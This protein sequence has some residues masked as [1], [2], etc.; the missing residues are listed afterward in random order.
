MPRSRIRVRPERLACLFVAIAAWGAIAPSPARCEE[1]A[2]RPL[3]NGKDLSGWTPKIRGEALGGEELDA[4]YWCRNLRDPVRFDRALAA[5]VAFCRAEQ[6]GMIDCQQHTQH[7]ASLGARLLPR[8]QF[9]GHLAAT[10]DAPSPWRWRPRS[11]RCPFTRRCSRRPRR[12]GPRAL[13]FRSRPARQAIFSPAC[14][15]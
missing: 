12:A 3:F 1:P 7:L 8:P 13:W 6:I 9:E 5:L 11:Y 4:E 10:V 15:A 14:S 2:W